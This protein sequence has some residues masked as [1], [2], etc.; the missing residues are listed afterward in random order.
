[1]ENDDQRPLQGTPTTQRIA[2]ASNN[3]LGAIHS[4]LYEFWS[5]R[6]ALYN[7]HGGEASMRR[8]A[9]SVI[10]FDHEVTTAIANDFRNGPD[11]LL[12]VVLAYHARG[13]TDYELA[14][15][16][17]QTVME[18]HWSTDRFVSLPETWQRF[19]TCHQISDCH[20]PVRWRV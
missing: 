8:D 14:M 2:A 17:V 10:L 9:Y 15:S 13:G 11:A 6:A 12:N 19:M 7:A 5:A 20:L 3:R 4:A 1:M 16:T 18:R